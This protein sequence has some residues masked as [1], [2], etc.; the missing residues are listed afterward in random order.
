MFISGFFSCE[1]LKNYEGSFEK[2]GLLMVFLPII[3]SAGGNSGTQ[4]ASL[5][6][7]GLAIKELNI[8]DAWRVL[9]KEIIVGLVL[10]LLLAFIGFGRSV[11]WGMGSQIGML[12]GC[13]VLG[14]VVFGVVVGSM[15]PFLLQKMKLD[16]AVVSSPLISTLMDVAGVLIYLRFSLWFLSSFPVP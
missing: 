9:N 16:P 10:G 3:I 5:I 13:S 2:W 4:A 15:L 8:Q 1:I 7:R 11:T 6:I 14:V 12:I